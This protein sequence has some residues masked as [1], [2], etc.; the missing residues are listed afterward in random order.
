M[1]FSQNPHGRPHNL[2]RLGFH[3]YGFVHLSHRQFDLE[4]KQRAVTHFNS[5]C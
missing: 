4:P 5:Y 3:F 1:Y 2:H